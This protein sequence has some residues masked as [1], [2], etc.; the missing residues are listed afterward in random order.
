MIKIL[1]DA[2]GDG[3]ITMIDAIVALQSASGVIPYIETADL[4]QDGYREMVAEARDGDECSYIVVYDIKHETKYV[5]NTYAF[6]LTPKNGILLV[7]GFDY[8]NDA[9]C[10]ESTMKLS[11]TED[12]Y[13]LELYASTE[14]WYQ[15]KGVPQ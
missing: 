15:K 2:D 5:L 14:L 10:E 1:G 11:E 13:V 3:R 9:F 8:K 4:N 6:F 12:G 7:N